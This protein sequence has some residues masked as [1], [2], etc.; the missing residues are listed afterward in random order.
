[1]KTCSTCENSKELAEFNKN[2]AQKDGYN[3]ECRF[4]QKI[5]SADY[6]AR[7][8]RKA[9]FQAYQDRQNTLIREKR[10]SNPEWAKKRDQQTNGRKREAPMT[11]ESLNYLKAMNTFCSYCGQ[12]ADTVDHVFPV[13]RGGD[14]H[15]LNLAPSCKSC[16]SS[17]GDKDL[18]TWL[19]GRPLCP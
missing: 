17:K 3:N 14:S 16:N 2:K 15:W 4:C 12:P 7:N 8:P 5:R 19:H 11:P 6:R 18:N 13:A 9:Y 1:M 10:K